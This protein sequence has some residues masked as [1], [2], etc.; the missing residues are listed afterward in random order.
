MITQAWFIVAIMSGMYADGTKDVFIFQHPKDHGHFH[1]SVMC[2]KFVGDNPFPIM[3]TLVSQYGDRT[4]E[5]IMCVPKEAVET[6]VNNSTEE[7][8]SL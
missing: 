1:S 4:P 5:K 3:K 2:Q 6:L 8:T 7:K